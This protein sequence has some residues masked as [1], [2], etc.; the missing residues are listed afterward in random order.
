ML[1]FITCYLLEAMKKII[2]LLVDN[3]LVI[4]DSLNTQNQVKVKFIKIMSSSELM[5][6]HKIL[7]Q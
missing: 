5:P 4:I 7:K 2:N 3:Y 6:G 1:L